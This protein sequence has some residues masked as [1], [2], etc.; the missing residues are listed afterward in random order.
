MDT[1]Y[2]VA[3]VNRARISGGGKRRIFESNFIWGNIINLTT[4][5]NS[6]LKSLDCQGNWQDPSSAIRSTDFQQWHYSFIR[7]IYTSL[8]PSSSSSPSSLD[9]RLGR[10]N[11]SSQLNESDNWPPNILIFEPVN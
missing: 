7:A 5:K 1:I 4:R 8:S 2:I 3:M 6:I 9:I 11:L 10:T